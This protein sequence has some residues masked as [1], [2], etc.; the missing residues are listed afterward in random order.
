MRRLGKET[1]IPLDPERTLN[2][3]RRERKDAATHLQN[4]MENHLNLGNQPN[5]GNNP[6]L[7]GQEH[8]L[9]G[10]GGITMLKSQFINQ[11]THICY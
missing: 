3:L 1:L 2:R 6:N 9:I 5:P 7:R 4:S 10:N 11:M 8:A